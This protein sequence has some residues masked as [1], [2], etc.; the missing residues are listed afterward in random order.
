M[1]PIEHRPD[2]VHVT[3]VHSA[4]DSRIFYREALS[5]HKSGLR[6]VVI[7]PSQG[8]GLVSGINVVSLHKSNVK[9]IRRLF[10]P[11]AA[12]RQ[13]LILRPVVVHFHDPEILPVAFLLK[14]LGYK[15]V[16]DIHEYYSEVLTVHIQNAPLRALK[17]AV[18]SAFVEKIPCAF[19]DRS[20]FPTKALRAAI[21][22]K[23]DAVAC[24]NLLPTD[25][26]PAFEGAISK[27]FDIIFMGTMSPFRAGPFLELVGLL[28]KQRAGFK[29][30]L[31]GVSLETQNWMRINATSTDVFSAITFLPRVPH[32]EV[33]TV[34]RRARIGFN[35]HPMQRRFM[36]ALP[37]KV[38]EYMACGL[39]VVCTRFPELA[40]QVTKDEMVLVEGDDQAKYAAAIIELLEDPA[41]LESMA[42]A[43]ELA[44]RSRLNWEMSEAPKLISMY[45]ELLS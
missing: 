19:L 18:V 40:D 12:L 37:M 15:V 22:D 10:A 20:V 21:H 33:A 16:W 27:D 30:A 32:A 34:L 9:F 23:N 42:R 6:T 8:H 24:V 11:F 4:L 2:L 3:T 35:Y 44:V 38:Y 39:P 31:L 17:R 29:A 45:R 36:V 41:K 26:F 43:G 25:V 7:G 13:I 14:L 1:P 5:A 28:C